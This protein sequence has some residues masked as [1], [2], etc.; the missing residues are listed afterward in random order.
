MAYGQQSESR[1]IN[2]H[3]SGIASNTF[4]SGSTKIVLED[5]KMKYNF[6]TL[7]KDGNIS[8]AGEAWNSLGLR[9]GDNIEAEVSETPE[10]FPDP[11]TGKTVNYTNRRILFFYTENPEAAQVPQE[12]PSFGSQGSTPLPQPTPQTGGQV[13]MIEM[14]RKLDIIVSLLK[15][16]VQA[17]AVLPQTHQQLSRAVIKPAPVAPVPEPEIPTINLDEDEIKIEDVPF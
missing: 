14:D 13:S 11:K 9:I 8:K 15:G 10:N 3:I 1:K 2:I 7:K 16:K 17:D 5:G 12:R 6:F 4:P